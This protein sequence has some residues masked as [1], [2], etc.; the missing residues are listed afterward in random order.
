MKALNTKSRM[1]WNL[2]ESNASG[3]N[4]TSKSQALQ[5]FHSISM[6]RCQ[7]YFF[8]LIPPEP[9]C[10]PPRSQRATTLQNSLRFQPM[11]SLVPP[12]EAQCVTAMSAGSFGVVAA[13]PFPFSVG[14]LICNVF[15][16]QTDNSQEKNLRG[17]M[18]NSMAFSPQLTSTLFMA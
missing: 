12:F 13:W 7:V 10:K 15:G 9:E 2:A 16:L 4:P 5:E 6:F 17:Y 14:Q 1:V 11:L 18:P 8:L 3:A